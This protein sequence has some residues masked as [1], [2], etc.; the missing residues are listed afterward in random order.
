MP[1][2]RKNGRRTRQNGPD[3]DQ[4]RRAAGPRAVPPPAAAE[5]TDERPRGAAVPTFAE[6]AEEF[7]AR[8]APQWRN[9]RTARSY[10]Q[11]LD[12]YV[13][14]HLG[15][16]PVD[17]IDADAVARVVGPHWRGF[18][19]RGGRILR[20]IST[21]MDFA[22]VQGHRD[23][24]PVPSVRQRLPVVRRQPRQHPGIPHGEVAG[25][26]ARIRA[27]GRAGAGLG[28]DVAALALELLI[29][30][31]ARPGLVREA[32]W[33]QFDLERRTWTIPA[34]RMPSGELHVVPLSRQAMDV[35]DRVRR[36]VA[37]TG[38]LFQYRSGGGLRPLSAHKLAYFMR[39]LQLGVVPDGFRAGFCVWA[40]AVAG[41]PPELVKLALGHAPTRRDSLPNVRPTRVEARREYMQR[42]ADHVAPD[43]RED[44]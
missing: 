22:V 32:R 33:D 42:W 28:D 8:R 6:L 40:A 3:P 25:V 15:G 14:S 21:V 9:P 31:A 24:N 35:L 19:S 18:D 27:A 29:L 23:S 17:R 2:D 10:R 44:G 16:L 1:D 26:L 39:T 12:A 13:L 37:G 36:R 5:P 41:M 34:E 20:Q 4:T 43:G 38:L 11:L 30:T 7:I